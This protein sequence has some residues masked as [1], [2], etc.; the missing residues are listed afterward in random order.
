MLDFLSHL[1]FFFKNKLNQISFLYFDHLPKIVTIVVNYLAAHFVYWPRILYIRKSVVVGCLGSWGL[2]SIFFLL[3]LL[4][5][6]WC[7]GWFKWV[8]IWKMAI[9]KIKQVIFNKCPL[10]KY[11][12]KGASCQVI[13]YLM[14]SFYVPFTFPW[15]G[16]HIIRRKQ[17]N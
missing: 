13:F 15:I 8:N 9:K 6:F 12:D 11:W 1:N 5:F 17:K 3:L 10:Q 14:K 16:A 2:L 7:L 4:L